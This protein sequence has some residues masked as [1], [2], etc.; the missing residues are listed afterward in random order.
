MRIKQAMNDYLTLKA[1]GSRSLKWPVDAAFAVHPDF[2]SHTGA[3][4]KMY[5]GAITAISF[6]Q[7]L[8]TSAQQQLK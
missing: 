8:N 4:M 2:N 6:K 7:S 3:L 5:K 1:E